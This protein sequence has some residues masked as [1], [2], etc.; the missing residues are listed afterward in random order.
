MVLRI[1]YL[2][3]NDFINEK[4]LVLCLGFFD[5]MH[6][7]HIKLIEEARTVAK[8]KGLLL[9]V[10]TFN[11]NVKAYLKNERHRCLT[12]IEDK[13]EICKKYDVDYLYVMTVSDHLIHMSPKE[14]IAR[15]LSDCDTLVFGFDFRFG[16]KGEGDRHLLKRSTRFDS[17]VIPEMKYMD[18]K[19]G[20]TRIKANLGDGN[21]EM[22]NYLLGRPYSIKGRVVSGRGIGRKLGYPTANIDYMPYI[23]PLSGVYFTYVYYKNKK[24]FGVT[25]VGNKPTYFRLPITLETYVFDMK[26]N[27][28][29]QDIKIEF[30]EYLRP[31][32]KF[33]NEEDLKNA[34]LNDIR[35]VER[36]F[37]EANHDKA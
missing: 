1:K 34:I 10:F 28:Y 20:T 29:N 30:I 19:V 33:D 13:A 8:K 37:K 22:A 24:Y 16:Y 6:I 31:E 25:N 7:A 4:N 15:F 14:F 3:Y 32:I 36:K 17:I 11:M 23:L 12:T 5:G 35:Y 26:E 18:L 9:A 21:L 27:L 2:T